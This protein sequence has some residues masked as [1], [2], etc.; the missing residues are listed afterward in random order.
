M[1]II[2]SG[3][4]KFKLGMS[5]KISKSAGKSFKCLIYDFDQIDVEV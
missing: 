4:A 5:L 2:S 1:S 3:C